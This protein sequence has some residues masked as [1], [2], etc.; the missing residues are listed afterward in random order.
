MSR[1]YGSEDTVE[2]FE[3]KDKNGNPVFGFGCYSGISGVKNAQDDDDDACDES[4][5][6]EFI[7]E[8]QKC[9]ADDDAVII[10]ESGNEK[11]RYVTGSA[12]IITSQEVGYL[13]IIDLATKKAAEMLGNP[14]WK[15]KCDY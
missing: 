6:D 7:E 15:T 4:A 12:E 5:Y 8:L 1:V 14:A 10:L 3:E 2:L 11:L 13:S 9:I